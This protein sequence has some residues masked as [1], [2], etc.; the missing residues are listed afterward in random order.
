MQKIYLRYKTIQIKKKKKIYKHSRYNYTDYN[1]V[2][3]RDKIYK[4]FTKNNKGK[5]QKSWHMVMSHLRQLQ[6][7]KITTVKAHSRGS[8]KIGIRLKDY[9]VSKGK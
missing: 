2:K 8:K 6:N 4:N 9:E 5:K 1:V 7:G 3:I